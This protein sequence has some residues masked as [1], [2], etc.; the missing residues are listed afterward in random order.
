[1]SVISVFSDNSTPLSVTATA[2]AGSAGTS[3]AAGSSA[4]ANPFVA[5]L[6]GLMGPAAELGT[7][8]ADVLSAEHELGGT[9]LAE[10]L[11]GDIASALADVA[12]ALGQLKSSKSGALEMHNEVVA[13]DAV[14]DE[15][16]TTNTANTEQLLTPLLQPLPLRQNLGAA[17]R[18]AAGSL[19]NAATADNAMIMSAAGLATSASSKQNDEAPSVSTEDLANALSKPAISSSVTSTLNSTTDTLAATKDSAML[20]P[21]LSAM[22]DALLQ[23][24]VAGDQADHLMSLSAQGAPASTALAGSTPTN[25]A[26]TAMSASSQWTVP[27]HALLDNTAWS[28]AMADR[29]TWLGQN[30]MTS[31]SLHITPDDLGPIHVRIQMSETGAKVAFSADHHDTQGLLERMLPKLNAAFEAQGLRL[32]DVR[33]QSGASEAAKMDFNQQQGGRQT[34]Q[35]AQTGT[36]SSGQEGRSNG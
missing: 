5:L 1:M 32:D 26:P 20:A 25:A 2:A 10:A 9:G 11:P 33:V 22:K 36:G 7:G 24:G 31:A 34:A 29:L 15:A 6:S 21:A 19:T 27:G 18:T 13:P 8:A 4:A 17:A 28:S 3:S 35:Q 14:D 23:A 16:L 12:E 30:G